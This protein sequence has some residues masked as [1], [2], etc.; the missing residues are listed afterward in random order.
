MIKIGDKIEGEVIGVF[1]SS[2]K[3]YLLIEF[4]GCNEI[5]LVR[6]KR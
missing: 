2:S 4:E 1:R 3:E 5:V 6:E